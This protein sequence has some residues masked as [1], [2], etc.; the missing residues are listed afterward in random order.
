[1]AKVIDMSIESAKDGSAVR[2][3][4]VN[5]KVRK[6]G[7]QAK[8]MDVVRYTEPPQ[9]GDEVVRI[10]NECDPIGFLAD[11]VNGK[12]IQCHVV[13]ED[14]T[15]HTFYETPDLKKRVEVAKFLAERYMPKVAVTKHAHLIKNMDEPKGQADPRGNFEQ[16]VTHAAA[17]SDS[18]D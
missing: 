2:A 17:A 1:M 15:V 5:L 9:V 16:M 8:Q 14:G 4:V 12:A 6:N 10:I 18:E 11:V 7:K 3:P 13:D